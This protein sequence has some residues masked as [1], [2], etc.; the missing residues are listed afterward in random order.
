[1]TC[2]N[3]GMCG[4]GRMGST[5]PNP[6]IPKPSDPD[7]LIS[8][9]ATLVFSG[10]LVHW[11]YPAVNPFAV[12]YGILYRG[13]SNDFSLA[14]KQGE[15]AGSSYLDVHNDPAPVTY[16]YWIQLV[17]VNGTVA[18]PVGPASATTRTLGAQTLESLT[19]MIDASV[20][21]QSLK[22]EI[23]RIPALDAHIIQEI[24]DRLAAN[25]VLANALA[26]VQNDVG[27][28]M[29]YV[30]QE[31]TQRTEGDTALVTAIDA[32]AAGSGGNAAAITHE[33]TVRADADSAMASD[34]V[35]LY[36][37]AG[38]NYAA[39][40][41]EATTRA[42]AIS[43]AANTVTALIATVGGNTAAIQNELSVRADADG[44]LSTRIDAMTVT[45]NGNLAAI[46]NEATVRANADSAMAQDI[47]TLFASNSSGDITA[48]VQVE[49]NAR[50][51]A[52]N[53]LANQITTVESTAA[54]NLSQAQLT[55]QTNIDT[56]TGIASSLITA[57]VETN[58]L[59]GGFG[60]YNDGYRVDAGFDVD[61]FWIGRTQANKVKPFIIYGDTVY[62]DKARIR[63]ADID[64]LKV[65]G[66]AITVPGWMTCGS[67]DI[68]GGGFNNS[69]ITEVFATTYAYAD[70]ASVAVFVQWGAMD[71]NPA[72]EGSGSPSMPRM[73][74]VING[75]VQA[76]ESGFGD[77]A[78]R[79]YRFTVPAG[80]NR[81]SVQFSNHGNSNGASFRMG[82]CSILLIGTMR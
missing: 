10:I 62:I 44:A 36:S 19:G 81:F 25:T 5:G 41:N 24:N 21:A 76:T 18:T 78:L 26:A 64:T 14:V 80:N 35:T 56:V 77:G 50:I 75:A 20:L 45:A 58:G 65:G 51:A 37:K 57:K 72:I 9:A 74:I 30:Q 42:D 39:I 15:V 82:G 55:L 43:A 27:A 7:N 59:I 1:M 53:S 79:M 54:G 4:T 60:I 52:D 16:F 12:A 49:T 69:P 31:I 73:E 70:A 71:L 38:E 3:D 47:Q 22:T 8:I 6:F 23:A 28:A 61:L 48:A 13:L 46:Q 33:A 63:D 40:I 2:D 32:I 11:T 34:I 66:N 17:S 68:N 29:T 67:Y